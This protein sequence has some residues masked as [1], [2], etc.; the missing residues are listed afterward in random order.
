MTVARFL[1]T[2]KGLLILGFA[3]LLIPAIRNQRLDLVAPRLLGSMA[4]A[5]ALDAI[6]IRRRRSRWHFPDGAMLTALIVAMI[7]DPHEP[8]YVGAVTSMIAVVSKY[9]LRVRKANVFNPA[10]LAL[11]IAY[12]LF[13]S[14]ENWW[15]AVPDA[16]FGIAVVLVVGVI[17]AQRV[18]K[19][20][21]MFAFLIVYYALASALAFLGDPA[22][23]AELYR[24]PDVNA[25]AFFAVFMVTDP[26]TSPSRTRDQVTFGAITG[27]VALAAYRI[28]G[29]AY[30]L[31]A[32]VLVA[33]AWDAWRRA[34]A[35]Y[36]PRS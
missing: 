7:L 15:G 9:A 20:P 26:P 29:S 5:M 31:L 6:I 18:D 22:K 36:I 28:I 25:A 4:A 8:W 14:A 17:I 24:S 2:P 30:Y 13:G 21:A 12:Y 32:G 3:F 16:R 23:V 1:R 27:V 10:A 34:P 35:G 19:T 11:V 33:N